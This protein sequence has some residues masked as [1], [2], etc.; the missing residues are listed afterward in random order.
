MHRSCYQQGRV[1]IPGVPAEFVCSLSPTPVPQEENCIVHRTLGKKSLTGNAGKSM[2]HGSALHMGE[3]T[4]DLCPHATV[5]AS[6]PCWILP[7]LSSPS[8]APFYLAI[9]SLSAQKRAQGSVPWLQF[10]S[11]LLVFTLLPAP[12]CSSLLSAQGAQLPGSQSR[13]L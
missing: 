5:K 11:C 9:S 4:A 1:I 6:C 7:D 3:S 12:Q 10:G 13:A 2:Q 8:P